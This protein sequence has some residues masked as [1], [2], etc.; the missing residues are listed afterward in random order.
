LLC[1]LSLLLSIAPIFLLLIIFA[2]VFIVFV[3]VLIYLLI[4]YSANVIPLFSLFV[5]FLVLTA[6]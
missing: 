3:V 2:A 5:S 6:V 4:A 1:L